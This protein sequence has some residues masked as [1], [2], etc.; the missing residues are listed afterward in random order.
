MRT[1]IN[2]K[3]GKKGDRKKHRSYVEHKRDK[4]V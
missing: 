2:P 3:E 4:I 1:S